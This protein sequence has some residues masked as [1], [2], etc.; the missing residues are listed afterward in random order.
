[1]GTCCSKPVPLSP[2]LATNDR[3]RTSFT[4]YFKM[5][6]TSGE[7][8]LYVTNLAEKAGCV[9]P[10]AF[11]PGILWYELDTIPPG[12]TSMH[13]TPLGPA[14][15]SNFVL[16]GKC[17]AQRVVA[18]SVITD[19]R[20]PPP[21]LVLHHLDLQREPLYLVSLPRS[22]MQTVTSET[23][24]HDMH[25]WRQSVHVNYGFDAPESPASTPS[26]AHLALLPPGARLWSAAPAPAALSSTSQLVLGAALTACIV[27]SGR[28]RRRL[29]TLSAAAVWTAA[30]TCTAGALL[31][32]PVPL[33]G[34]MRADLAVVALAGQAV[35]AALLCLL[36]RV[37]G[38]AVVFAIAVLLV[39]G[40]LPH[41]SLYYFKQSRITSNAVRL[42][43]AA[44]ASISSTA[45]I[46]S[47]ELCEQL[48][49]EVLQRHAEWT[50][51]DLEVPVPYFS[52]GVSSNHA[53]DDEAPPAWW[54]LRT[55]FA[56]LEG[57]EGSVVLGARGRAHR[58]RVSSLLRNADWLNEPLRAAM[59]AHLGV[60]RERVVFG[61]EGLIRHLW[62]PAV[63][64][65]LPSLAWAFVVNP[66]IDEH[67]F[68]Q[69]LRGS[70]G[71]GAECEESTRFAFLIPLHT[72]SGSGLLFWNLL[73]QDG[74]ATEE[75]VEHV[76][77][78]VRGTL[79]SWPLTLPH[80]LH[81]WTLAEWDA[82]ALRV[83]LQLFGVLCGEMWYFYH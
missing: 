11:E 53:R 82:S 70:P 19:E 62:H 13:I 36:V 55:G 42:A 2:E 6:N 41:E 44:N 32:L 58:E 8:Q 28:A 67:V 18:C 45:G 16:H 64:I 63:Q 40:G 48:Y 50:R 4:H 22:G 54:S 73:N 71:G 35:L 77:P 60:E 56:A 52:L 83:T 69:L 3:Q 80:A 43:A 9:Q 20:S 31:W 59:S 47:A 39:R 29:A 24:G 37:R 23:T 51:A 61:G 65:Y 57:N 78:Y 66:H 46:F 10:D 30:R 25:S 7:Q 75:L 79:Y 26:D 34:Y 74:V 14:A 1:M 17:D 81:P 12:A 15:T 27:L 21:S 38:L 68:S 72:P 5:L 49:A 33:L 76:Q